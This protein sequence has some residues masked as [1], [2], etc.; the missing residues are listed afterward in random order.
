MHSTYL[1][2]NINVRQNMFNDCITYVYYIYIHMK[3]VRQFTCLKSNC[4][5]NYK[6][7]IKFTIP[8]SDE[9]H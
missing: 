9:N 3:T 8:T 1:T 5:Y 4:T 2:V 7:L 6:F